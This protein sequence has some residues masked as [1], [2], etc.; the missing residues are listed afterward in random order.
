MAVARLALGR[1]EDAAL[2]A[3]EV[4]EGKGYL[5]DLSHERVVSA[6]AFFIV[7]GG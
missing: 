3:W 6:V 7:A 1:Y 2:S 5:S 4:S